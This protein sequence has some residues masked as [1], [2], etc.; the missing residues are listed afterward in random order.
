VIPWLD[1]NEPFPPVQQAL[2]DPDGLLCATAS[3]SPQLIIQAYQRGIFPWYGPEQPVLWWSPNPRMVLYPDELHLTRSLQKN[4]RNQSYE[5]RCDTAF[6]EVI[7][8]CAEPRHPEGHANS[9][10]WIS[11]AVQAAYTALHHQG[12]AHSIEC[13]Q[14]QQLVGGFYGLCLGRVFYGESMFSRVRDGSKL[15]F[16]NMVPVLAQWGVAIIDC[17]VYTDYLASLGA[18]L[19]PREAFLAELAQHVSGPTLTNDWS[20]WVY[21]HHSAGRS[22]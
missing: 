10:T 8:A 4:L 22:T 9:G 15:A 20:G 18:R 12:L 2:T 16:A 21:H 11:P 7:A 6:A 1:N 5:I 14:N 3:L 19:I 17:Q 13:W